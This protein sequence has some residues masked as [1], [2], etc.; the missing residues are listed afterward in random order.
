MANKVLCV[1][2]SQCMAVSCAAT[3]IQEKTSVSLANS[4]AT[5]AAAGD[6][7]DA[8]WSEHSRHSRHKRAPLGNTVLVR[9]VSSTDV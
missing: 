8:D 3:C 4:A 6:E 5:A 2:H 7:I 9:S 1:Y